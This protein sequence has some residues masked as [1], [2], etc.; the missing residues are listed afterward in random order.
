[1]IG[2]LAPVAGVRV[3]GVHLPDPRLVRDDTARR[4]AAGDHSG[5]N[6]MGAR[7]RCSQAGVLITCEATA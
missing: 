2:H 5:R 1:M 4:G 3:E 7:K 6:E